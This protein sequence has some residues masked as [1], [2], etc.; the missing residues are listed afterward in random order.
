MCSSDLAAM[1]VFLMTSR[2]EGLPNV[3]IEAQGAGV[4]VVSAMVGGAPETFVNGE[5]GYAVRSAAPEAF[6]EAVLTIVN[7][8]DARL[9]MSRKAIQ[10]ARDQFSIDRMISRTLGVYRQKSF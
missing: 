10:H 6:A 7:D 3:L 4:P 5:T 2:M 1:D 9:K 8:K